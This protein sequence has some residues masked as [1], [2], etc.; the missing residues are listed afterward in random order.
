MATDASLEERMAAVEETISELQKQ[1]AAPQ[2]TSWVQQITGSFKDDPVFEKIL[3][4]GK[5]I[6]AGD[7]TLL[8]QGG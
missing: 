2:G 4:Y 7:E 3:E 1:V 6:R 8:E 5:A